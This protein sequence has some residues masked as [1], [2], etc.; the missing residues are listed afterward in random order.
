MALSVKDFAA[1]VKAKYPEYQNVDDNVLAQKVLDKYPEYKDKVDMS[2]SSAPAQTQPEP[3]LLSQAWNALKKPEEWVKQGTEQW[4]NAAKSVPEFPYT[5][6][7]VRDIALN[8]PKAINESVA[9]TLDKVLPGT[10]SRSSLATM[11]A[12]EAAPTVLAPVG[13][14]IAKGAEGLS[15][16]VYKTPGVLVEAFKNPSLIFKGGIEKAR[17]LYQA[18][19]E[20]PA[21]EFPDLL[22]NQNAVED[23]LAALKQGT[24]APDKAL[25]ARKALDATKD[26][27]TQDSFSATRDAFNQVAKQKFSEADAAYR[28]GMQADALRTAY[29]LNVSG[30]PS[31]LQMT[32]GLGAMLSRNPYAIGMAAASSPLVQG[33]AASGLGAVL[34]P[35][36]AQPVAT[37]VGVGMVPSAIELFNQA[38]KRFYDSQPQ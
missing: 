16:L 2:Q 1:T 37:G 4:V 34:N 13:N 23:A 14:L 32:A 35:A 15:G 27:Y 38:K 7:T 29:P 25:E 30:T 8:A 24:L 5:G 9:E 11:G 26:L 22:K 10:V 19:K 21:A 28:T 31:K 36:L 18:A 33:A 17:A 20:T 3:G 6:N 12:L